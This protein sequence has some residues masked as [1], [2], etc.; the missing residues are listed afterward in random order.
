LDAIYRHHLP[1]L[2]PESMRAREHER[3]NAAAI[4]RERAEMSEKSF[5]GVES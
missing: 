1:A 4:P 3:Q 5:I 2:V